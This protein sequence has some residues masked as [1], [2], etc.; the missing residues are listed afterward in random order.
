MT[1]IVRRMSR[2]PS[3][4][5]SGLGFPRALVAVAI[6]TLAAIGLSRPLHA[7]GN[8]I[9]GRVQVA[10]TNEPVRSAQIS[11]AGT[12]LGA[13]SDEQGQFRITGVTGTS[14]TLNV[15]RIGYRTETVTARAGQTDLVVTL[16]SNP[17][18]LEATV[19]TGQSGA[20]ARREIGNSVGSIDAS[21]IVA[22]APVISM[23]GLLNGRTPSLVVMP[24][25]GQ[26][27]TGSQ[28][29]IRGIASLSLG[30]NPLIFVD[31]VRVNNQVASGPESQSFSSAPI[32]R[33]NDFNPED[34]ESIEVLKGPSASTLYGTEAANGVINIITKKG[35][36]NAARWSFTTRQGVN[37]FADWKTRFPQNYGPRRLP[38]DA[39]YGSPTGPV[40]ALN[41]D[42]L[43]V[44][45]CGDSI[46]TR[47]GKKCDF[48]RNGKHQE[49]EISV[50]G[51]TA[52]LNYYASGNLLDDQ[53]AEPRSSRRNYNGRLNVSLAPSQKLNIAANIGFVNGPTNLP[54]DG[55]C[56]GGTQT[57]HCPAPP[58]NH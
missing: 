18:S 14:V 37:Y 1:G 2:S 58:P 24:T 44:G 46:S 7:Q 32:S 40:E 35:G 30:N 43:L 27:G 52:L 57:T 45:A 42:Y 36:N 17:T 54:C 23:Q 22:T 21:S 53:G 55:G 20:T 41:F 51:G 48:F 9:A 6:G 33:L 11:V 50:T 12:Q 39:P 34:I 15:R 3:W 47:L 4:R 31:G 25:S 56:G 8:S 28:I 29:R 10:G 13:V 19:V 49:T 16:T 5:A 38:T 26:V